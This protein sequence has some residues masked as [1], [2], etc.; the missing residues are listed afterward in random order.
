M[1]ISRIAAFIL[2]LIAV[3]SSVFTLAS[4]GEEQVI[5]TVQY[6]ADEGKTVY[7]KFE[8]AEGTAAT[9][10]ENPE[11]DGYDFAGWFYDVECERPM[12]DGYV[13]S[14]NITFYA[15][16]ITHVHNLRHTE[17]K[18]ATCMSK[19][20]V[21]YWYCNLCDKYYDGD[22]LAAAELETTVLDNGT[23]KYDENDKCEYCKKERNENILSLNSDKK[24]YTYIGDGDTSVNSVT[25]PDTYKDLPITAIADSAFAGY[26]NITEILI[27]ESIEVIG[28]E[29]FFG[30]SALTSVKIPASVTSIGNRAFYNCVSLSKVEFLAEALADLKAGNSVFGFDAEDEN[31]NAPQHAAISVIIGA[32]VKS[33]PAY[34][35]EN[36]ES[37]ASV[38]FEDASVC[39]TIGASAFAGTAIESLA[40]PA[41]VTSVNVGAFKNCVFLSVLT[42][43][44]G[45]EKY[46]A[47]GNCLLERK[48]SEGEEAEETYV[49]VAG[50]NGSVIPETVDGKPVV[51]IA[52]YAFCGCKTLESVSI[53]AS[54]TVIGASAFFGCEGLTE[55]NVGDAITDIGAS[56]FENCSSLSAIVIPKTVKNIGNRAFYN[57]VSL[58]NITYLAEQVTDFAEGNLVF[59]YAASD[60][61][62]LTESLKLTV[63][64]GVK[65]IPSYFVYGIS[66]KEPG[67]ATLPVTEIVIDSAE[68]DV[69]GAYAFANATELGEIVYNTV[70][71]DDLAAN[72]YVFANAGVNTDGIKLVV[73]AAV[74]T[75]PQNLF[76]PDAKGSSTVKLSEVVFEGTS[77]SKIGENAFFSASASSEARVSV[78][79]VDAWLSVDFENIYANPLSLGAGLYIDGALIDTLTVNADKVGA[80]AF[81]GHKSLKS[82]TVNAKSIGENAFYGC[83]ALESVNIGADVAEISAYAFVGCSAL[84]SASFANASGWEL[85]NNYDKS[86]GSVNLGDATAAAEELSEKSFGYTWKRK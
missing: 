15:K 43:D 28:A 22:G 73:G 63:G 11:K 86:V 48:V 33:V 40:L 81:A 52:D 70:N 55:V 14:E 31:G 27:P 16:W 67:N 54:V 4:C 66:E 35:F 12:E 39:E 26:T 78:V 71:C 75:I 84:K 7:K 38:V 74:E 42:I 41:S 69:I 53:P 59:A 76:A 36:C 65:S 85:Y 9:I 17:G 58:E 80:Y 46:V 72:N 60:D 29:A 19:G 23:H 21:E 47:L 82:V 44:E 50:T 3:V 24:S 10:P 51:A 49:V 25:I 32:G 2:T 45:N 61:V 62:T 30:C 83:S 1:K 6:S 20:N 79:S 56:A 34:V 8:I 57:C 18:E 68:L 37:V 13:A 5:F 77:V 64:E